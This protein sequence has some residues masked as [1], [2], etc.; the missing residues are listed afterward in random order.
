MGDFNI[1]SCELR[2][3]TKQLQENN[4]LPF[5]SFTSLVE[6]IFSQELS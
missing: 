2:L 4:I 1:V 6:K 5:L 3:L